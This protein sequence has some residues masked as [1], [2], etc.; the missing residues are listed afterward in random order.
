VPNIKVTLVREPLP[1]DIPPGLMAGFALGAAIEEL[2]LNV[3]L[4]EEVLLYSVNVHI[5]GQRF[6]IEND[7]E[8]LT[9]HDGSWVIVPASEAFNDLTI[10]PEVESPR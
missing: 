7:P 4:R 3:D 10:T 9:E 5:D 1:Q 8:G 6:T 2:M